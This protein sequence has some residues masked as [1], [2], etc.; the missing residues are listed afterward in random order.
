MTSAEARALMANGPVFLY[1]KYEQVVI[2]WDL[3]TRKWYVKRKGQ[4]EILQNGPS[5]LIAEAMRFPVTISEDKYNK[6]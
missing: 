4:K 5:D 1:D 3:S 2:R 6:F